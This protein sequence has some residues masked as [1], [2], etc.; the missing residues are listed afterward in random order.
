[1]TLT[2]ALVKSINTVPVRLAKEHLSI[3]PIKKLVEDMGI[4]SPVFSDK[5]MVLGTSGFTVL[6]QAT[7]YEVFA[8]GG[9]A[10]T[11]HGVTQITNLSGD[12]VYDQSRDAPAPRGGRCRP[13]GS[14]P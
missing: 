2:T 12:V 8:N 7:G 11:R 14:V 9:F 10:G 4:E 3:P 6:D 13:R 5:T 1:M